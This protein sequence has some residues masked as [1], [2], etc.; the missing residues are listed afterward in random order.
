MFVLRRAGKSKSLFPLAK[1]GPE[2]VG[3][4]PLR[5]SIYPTL[6]APLPGTVMAFAHRGLIADIDTYARWSFADGLCPLDWRQGIKHDA[7]AVMELLRDPASD[8]W[9]NRGGDVV[10]VEP[11]FIYPLVKGTDL[12]RSPSSRPE[13]ATLVTQTRLGEATE[14]LATQAPRL[15]RYLTMHRSHFAQRKSSIYR[16]QPPFSLFGIGP[17][18]FAPYKVAISGMHKQPRFRALPPVQG[19]PVMLDDTCYFLPCPTAEEASILTALCNDRITQ[20][21]LGSLIFRD[22]KRPITKKLLQRVDL[23]AVLQQTAP[24]HSSP[25]P[26]KCSTTSSRR[27]HANA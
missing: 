22:N 13:R 20:G 19:R 14:P 17:Y 10:D 21:L 18:S 16:G 7:A 11:E 24:T 2:G 4:T 12:T 23:L 26:L 27:P 1:G 3:E 6:S 15:W 9:H 8:G 5:I 25:G